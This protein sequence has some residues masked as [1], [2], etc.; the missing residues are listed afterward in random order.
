MNQLQG[1][2]EVEINGI[3]REVKFGTLQT[4]IFCQLRSINLNQAQELLSTE[5]MV[6]GEFDLMT[7][8]DFLYSAFVA[9]AKSAKKEV[10]FETSDIAD[11]MDQDSKLIE[12]VMEAATGANFPNE[13]QSRAQRRAPAK[14]QK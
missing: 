1:T 5:K 7:L 14:A 2:T 3:K 9:G 10:D 11:W 4:A 12:R 13:S 8:I 6:A